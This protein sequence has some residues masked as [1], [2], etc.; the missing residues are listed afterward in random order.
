[1]WE[2]VST[3]YTLYNIQVNKSFYMLLI[4]WF[5]FSQIFPASSF[6]PA[7]ATVV[8]IVFC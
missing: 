4:Y 8:D 1:M 6:C 5:I 7:R 3:Y 2:P